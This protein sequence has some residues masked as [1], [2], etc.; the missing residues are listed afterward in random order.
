MRFL[1][2]GNF[3]PFYNSN[4]HGHCKLMKREAGVASRPFGKVMSS[5][6]CFELV[7]NRPRLTDPR[8][9]GSKAERLVT[10]SLSTCPFSGRSS[11][12][13][14]YLFGGQGLRLVFAPQISTYDGTFGKIDEY[15]NVGSY[16]PLGETTNPYQFKVKTIGRNTI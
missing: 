7:Q 12:R 4:A 1:M 10:F 14:Q 15:Y 5:I 9:R 2:Q 8:C 13:K 16:I 6:C 3:S 11:F